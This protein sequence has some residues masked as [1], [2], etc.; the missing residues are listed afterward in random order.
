M[1]NTKFD[2][3]LTLNR[4][5]NAT[6][7]CVLCVAACVAAYP[8][9]GTRVGEEMDLP[10]VISSHQEAFTVTPADSVDVSAV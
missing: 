4:V 1:L 7:V 5:S 9:L 8:E 3:L 2:K 6:R 10:E